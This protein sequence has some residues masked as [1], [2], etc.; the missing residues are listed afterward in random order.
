MSQ[1]TIVDDA[2]SYERMGHYSKDQLNGL[3]IDAYDNNLNYHSSQNPNLDKKMV[4]A[5]YGATNGVTLYKVYYN[6]V[7][8]E[9][10]QVEKVSGLVAIPDGVSATAP[11]VSY[12][13]GTVLDNITVPSNVI[14]T[15]GAGGIQWGDA[16]TLVNL[17]RFGGNGYILS[18]ADYLGKGISEVQEAYAVKGATNQTNIDMLQAA[19]KVLNDLNVT[20]DKLFL[21]GQ[22]QGGLNTQWLTQALEN[23][24]VP[25]SASAAATPFNDLVASVQAWTSVDRQQP[26]NAYDPVPWLPPTVAIALSSYQKYYNI[27]G[28]L[29]AA[30]KPEFATQIKQYLANNFYYDWSKSTNATWT[31]EGG[32]SVPGITAKEMLVSGFSTLYTSSKVSE[33]FQHLSD[34]S[35]FNWR[36]TTPIRFY[37]GTTDEVLPVNVVT[38]PLVLGGDLVSSQSVLNGTHGGTFLYSL[39]AN[40]SSPASPITSYD[41]FNSIKSTASQS[42]HLALDA[43]E[44]SV[45]GD[46]YG[47]LKISLNASKAGSSNFGIVDIFSVTGD[48]SNGGAKHYL[49]SIGAISG[50]NDALGKRHHLGSAGA[51]NSDNNVLGK[52]DV[53]LQTGDQV[54][55]QSHDASGAIISTISKITQTTSG[56]QAVISPSSNANNS[57]LTID[58][59]QSHGPATLGQLIAATQSSPST[60]FLNLRSGD[61]INIH[62]QNAK[63]FSNLVGLVK[64]D[65]DAVT[66]LPTGSVGGIFPNS[67]SFT[68]AV[69]SHLVTNLSSTNLASNSSGDIY[70]VAPSNGVYAVVA[71]DANGAI[72]T[73]GQESYLDG[74]AHVQNIGDNAFAFET[75]YGS[76]NDGSFNDLV[77]QVSADVNLNKFIY[78]LYNTAFNRDAGAQELKYWINTAQAYQLKPINIVDAFMGTE[79]YLHNYGQGITNLDFVSK[80][81]QNTFDRPADSVGE[82]YW[83]G[84]LNNGLSRDQVILSFVKSVEAMQLIGMQHPEQPWAS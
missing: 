16:S 65:Q 73:Y 68:D 64:I 22:S 72:Y 79:E 46:S 15:D 67:A 81:Y 71:I 44:L 69:K 57:I 42:P 13:H 76:Q 20:P 74:K 60:D 5:K 35:A 24:S 80:L 9:S 3:L 12:Q 78:G 34:N 52:L 77:V 54:L 33:F 4:S 18:A 58:I 6:T 21:A 61:A 50:D 66:Q 2:V 37:Y 25:I 84:L 31:I 63:G 62:Y 10:G 39:F 43:N 83:V 23:M 48:I 30:I 41:W 26:N 56:Y 53:I 59:A 55:F 82:G 11:M 17:V 7:V 70:W 36:Y 14:K 45:S 38:K 47:T 29:D 49:G 27:N 19:N 40:N 28:L 8:P 32:G 75:A 51:I 1:I